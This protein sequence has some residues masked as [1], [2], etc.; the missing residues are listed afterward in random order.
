VENIDDR[1]ILHVEDDDA[2]AYLLITAIRILECRPVIYRVCDA[3]DAIAFL[4]KQAP[5]TGVPT[6]DLVLLDIN[7]AGR[8]G[9]DVLRDA[10]G[11]PDLQATLFVVFSTSTLE[12]DRHQAFALGADA[13]LSKPLDLDHYLEAVSS[14]CTVMTKKRAT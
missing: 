5:F 6:P 12:S 9:F 8:S 11:K 2:T 1:V 4:D 7:L 13:Y 3:D 14:A 10:K